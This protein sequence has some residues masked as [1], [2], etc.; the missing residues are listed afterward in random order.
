[1]THPT[2][3]GRPAVLRPAAF[4]LPCTVLAAAALATARGQDQPKAQPA[5][6]SVEAID[7]AFLRGVMDLE[8]ARLRQLEGLAGRQ[9]KDRAEATYIAYFRDALTV[10]LYRDAEPTAER[11]LASG[12]A[13]PQLL[14][15]AHVANIL[16]EVDR[17]AFDESLRSLAAATATGAEQEDGQPARS[18]LPAEVR[19]SLIETYYQKLVQ[20]S[21]F[22][23]ARRAF[24]IVRDRAKDPAFRQYAESR[25][26][27][28]ALIGQPAPP[29]AGKDVD[30]QAVD[31]AD[32]KGRVVLVDFW[33]SWCLPCGAQAVE[34]VGL[35]DAL[36]DQGLDI[37]GVNVDAMDPAVKDPSSVLP[38]VRRFLIDHNVRWPSVVNAPGESDLAKAYGVTEVPANFLVGRDGTIVAIDLTGPHLEAAVREA[39]GAGR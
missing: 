32:H 28:L 34:R 1:M 37:I 38:D 5:G 4:L 21:Q 36:H 25:L 2:H 24:T 14:Y 10:G 6:E 31:L 18:V 3:R 20:A 17:G 29:L 9:P 15:L 35:Y 11:L 33:A 16:A 26:A 22:D 30:G 19:Y 12:E 39:L 27:R 8:R 23:V 7:A 13:T